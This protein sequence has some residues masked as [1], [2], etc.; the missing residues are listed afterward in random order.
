MAGFRETVFRDSMKR[1]R[2]IL[3]INQTELARRMKALGYPFHQQTIQRVEA[4]ERPIRLDEAYAL[5]EILD[6]SVDSMTRTFRAEVSDVVYAVEKLRR[7]S[8]RL[9]DDV[10]E[11]TDDWHAAFEEV[12]AEYARSVPQGGESIDEWSAVVSAWIIKGLWVSESINELLVYLAGIANEEGGG[13]WHQP[14]LTR[15]IGDALGWLQDEAAEP[16]VSMPEG[17]RPLVIADLEP[18]VLMDRLK[19]LASRGSSDG[20][21]QAEA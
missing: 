11:V 12:F 15:D 13:D 8:R 16:W 7:E 20:E 1:R 2:E 5:A 6:T 4:G 17:D 21:H 14:V 18:S 9:Y 19:T 10:H 3:G